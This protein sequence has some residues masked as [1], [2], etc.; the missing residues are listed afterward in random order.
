MKTHIFAGYFREKMEKNIGENEQTIFENIV[1]FYYSF[2]FLRIFSQK[3]INMISTTTTTNIVTIVVSLC[4]GST[5]FTIFF[6][7]FWLSAVRIFHWFH[8]F[9]EQNTNIL[10][11]P[12]FKMCI[13]KN[14][15]KNQRSTVCFLK[16]VGCKISRKKHDTRFYQRCMCLQRCNKVL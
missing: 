12:N 6:N 15:K 2:I 1:F 10:G 3:M 8:G 5:C 14:T 7:F 4:A 9:S 13:K 16:S 11:F